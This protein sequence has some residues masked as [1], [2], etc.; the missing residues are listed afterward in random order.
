[1]VTPTACET[2]NQTAQDS[3]AGAVADIIRKLLAF[4]GWGPLPWIAVALGLSIVGAAA[5]YHGGRRR[6]RFSGSASHS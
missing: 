1:M 3:L 2:A 6:P 5:V 4:T